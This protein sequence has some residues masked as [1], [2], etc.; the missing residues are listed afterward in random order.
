[1]SDLSNPH[2]KFFKET[3]SQPEVARDFF[4]NYLPQRVTAVLDLDTLALQP[5]SFIDPDLQE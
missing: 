1:M 2:D 3:F 4:A 5:D